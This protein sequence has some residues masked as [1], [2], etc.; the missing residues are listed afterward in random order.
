LVT[1]NGKPTALN[2]LKDECVLFCR[3]LVHLNPS[4]YVLEK[5]QE[6]H[7]AKNLDGYTY[8]NNFDRL[9]MRLAIAAPLLTKIVDVYTRLFYKE[10]MVR[11]KLV[12][13]LAILESC[14]P[15]HVYID[16]PDK[17][18][19]YLRLIVHSVLFLLTLLISTILLLPTHVMCI[20]LSKLNSNSV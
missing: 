1:H 7:T 16:S 3:Y 19:F 17:G 20:L 6:G 10:S 14:H 15:Y 9:L 8:R 4:D 2:K 12:L 11:K 5:Y 18:D 13:L